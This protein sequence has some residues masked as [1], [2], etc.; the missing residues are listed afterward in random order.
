MQTLQIALMQTGKAQIYKGTTRVVVTRRFWE[1]RYACGDSYTVIEH[2]ADGSTQKHTW[3][4]I[5][6]VEAYLG[7]V[8]R[9]GE[10]WIAIRKAS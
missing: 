3:A 4:N 2:F 7:G 1:N 10:Q 9:F 5:W 8:A 6:N